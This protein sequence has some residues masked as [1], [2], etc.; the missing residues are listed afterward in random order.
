M[1]I[2]LL[3]EDGEPMILAIARIDRVESQGCR[4]R[5]TLLPLTKDDDV[6]VVYSATD[7]PEIWE[8]LR[9]RI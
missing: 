7:V 1:F 6:E 3:D 9:Q 4:S 2:E 8:K 5:I